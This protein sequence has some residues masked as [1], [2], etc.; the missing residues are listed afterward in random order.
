MVPENNDQAVSMASTFKDKMV[1]LTGDDQ[2]IAVYQTFESGA[3]DF[4]TQLQAN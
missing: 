4:S 3:E 2:A 1:E